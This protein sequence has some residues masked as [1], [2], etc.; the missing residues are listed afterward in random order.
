MEIIFASSAPEIDACLALR[1]EVFILEQEVP[2]ELELDGKDD[3]CRHVLAMDQNNPVGTA[4]LSGTDG[5][6]KIQRVCVPKRAR[7]NGIGEKMM[8]FVIADAQA[9]GTVERL[10]LSSQE[11]AIPFY[12]KLGFAITSGSYMDAGI[13]HKDMELVIKQ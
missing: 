9:S 7:S 3:Q 8:K 13:P 1:R 12:Q 11:S 4:R 5:T 6:V 2:E 10:V